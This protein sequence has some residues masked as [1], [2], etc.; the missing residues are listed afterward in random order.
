MPTLPIVN[1][2]LTPYEVWSYR[3]P[4]SEE[5]Q[6]FY[7]Q[8]G[9]FPSLIKEQLIET[10]DTPLK[11]ALYISKVGADNGIDIH[12]NSF[13]DKSSEYKL[14][15]K[16]MPYRTPH[17]LSNYQKKYPNYDQVAL[18]NEIQAISAV[19]SVN[20]SLF[21]GG[22][23]FNDKLSLIQTQRPLSTTFS[24][25]VALRNAEH[26]G[27]AYDAGRI[28]L[29]VLK[30]KNPITPVFV[31]RNKGTNLGHEN[32]ILFMSGA[33]LYLKNRILVKDNYPVS[34]VMNGINIIKKEVPIYVLE[35]EIE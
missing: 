34:K 30:V 5:M 3:N 35:I 18:D 21:H 11:A 23:W 29:F 19:L 28:D 8:N 24:P 12:I 27:K 14:M 10:I 6:V 13:L 1:P 15:R 20:Q 33:K 25:Q 17:E 26:K 32:E 22:S 7:E 16:L 2:F 4:T 31:F 9:Y